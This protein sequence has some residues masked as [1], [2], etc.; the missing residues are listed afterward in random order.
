M[1]V[2]HTD[3]S[4]ETFSEQAVVGYQ[5]AITLMCYEGELVWSK[6]NAMLVGNSIV[7]AILG[8]SVQSATESGPKSLLL[9]L[10]AVGLI[11]CFVWFV[12]V[13]QGF[14]HH[15]YWTL[16]A[17]ELEERFLQPPVGT[18]SKGAS[19]FSGQE[20]VLSIGDGTRTL[21]K[22]RLGLFMRAKTLATVSIIAFVAVY[23]S[24]AVYG[25][26]N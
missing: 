18:L 5:A 2:A 20:I 16:S 6:F 9:A 23:I 14:E 8:V 25:L 22:S 24:F 1:T 12:L 4:E 15:Y 10:S 13:T 7:L 3:K 21:K 26:L 11:L 19:Y 17:R